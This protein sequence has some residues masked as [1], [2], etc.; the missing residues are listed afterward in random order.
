M[1]AEGRPVL[2]GDDFYVLRGKTLL[3][4][5]YM[6]D[7]FITKYGKEFVNAAL[8]RRA[9]AIQVSYCVLLGLKLPVA[10]QD[11]NMTWERL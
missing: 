11:I 1:T 4:D 10:V 2:D 8:L 5:M 6:P 3:D 9:M 7:E